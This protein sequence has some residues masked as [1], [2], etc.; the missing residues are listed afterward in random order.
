MMAVDC[1]DVLVVGLGPA[2]CRA[3]EAA[4]KAG[5]SVIGVDRRHTPGE[6]VQCAEFVPALLGQELD[7]PLAARRQAIRE[8]VTFVEAEPPDS[9][10]DFRGQMIDR[11]AFDRLL[12]DRAR[13][14]GADCR[15]GVVVQAIDTDGA[16][17]LSSGRRVRAR[18]IVGADGP[19]SAVGRALGQ[20]NRQL[21]ETRQVTVPLL[22]P[23]AA[24]DIFLSADLVGGYGWMFPKGDVANV[25]AGVVPAARGRLKGLVEDL[26]R[27]LLAD[28]RIGP[29]ILGYTGGAIPVGGML[30][31][32]GELGDVRVLLAGDAAG[33][34]NP[35]TG[36]GIPAAVISG[37]L[38]GAAAVAHLG[39]D[40]DAVE[41]DEEDLADIF[42]P[43]LTRALARRRDILAAHDAGGAPRAADLRRTWIAY[44]E[45]WAA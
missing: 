12:L 9:R 1:C 32:H 11:A 16:A 4:A 40:A 23:L 38:T 3:A 22:A 26:R 24:T 15:F 44:P 36:A 33:L 18:V 43:S 17:D 8:M 39:G 30:T 42:G 6:P 29:E 28:G 34:T 27:R 7:T 5:L 21:V 25:G 35:V 37:A 41:D 2:G 31:P 10:D 14:A 19:R 20:V 45:Y 13:D